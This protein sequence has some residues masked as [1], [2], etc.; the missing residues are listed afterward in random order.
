[1][2]INHLAEHE[3]A[4]VRTSDNR[5][6]QVATFADHDVDNLEGINK[7]VEGDTYIVSGCNAG[8][9]PPLHSVWDGTTFI[10]ADN[11]Y[12]ISIGLLTE[13]EETE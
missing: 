5:V 4:F 6:I 1:M 12:Y 11:E 7:F 9:I 13:P 3:H 8:Q 10:P 2:A